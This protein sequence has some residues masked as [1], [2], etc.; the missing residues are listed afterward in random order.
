MG[1]GRMERGNSDHVTIPSLDLGKL[2]KLHIHNNGGAANAPDWAVGTVAIGSMKYLG[3]DVGHSTE[4]TATPNKFVF[5]YKTE[6][7]DLTPNFPEPPPTIECPAPMTVNND[8][9]KC[10]AVV[11]FSTP[12]AGMCNDV[13]TSY[14]QNP[15]TA[16]DV[17]LTNVTATASSPTTGTNSCSFNVTVK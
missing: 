6:H 10:S 15:G 7:I 16:F 1:T 14:T 11:N 12:A 13:T 9:G 4:Y 5:A 3:S 8:P 2:T 17:G